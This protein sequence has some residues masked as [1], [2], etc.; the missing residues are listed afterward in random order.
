MARY[1]DDI[2]EHVPKPEEKFQVKYLIE[3]TSKVV[4]GATLGPFENSQHH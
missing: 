1:S 3:K 4:R 2:L